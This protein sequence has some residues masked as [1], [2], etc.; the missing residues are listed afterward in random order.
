M[1][2]QSSPTNVIMPPFVNGWN[3][4]LDKIPTGGISMAKN[5]MQDA[6]LFL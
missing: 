3:K 4:S 6:D 1:R 2:N 5:L